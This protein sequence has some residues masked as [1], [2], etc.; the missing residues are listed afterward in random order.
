CCRLR[1][2]FASAP[3]YMARS[4]CG[5]ETGWRVFSG[6][7]S[8]NVPVMGHVGNTRTLYDRFLQVV[9]GLS[10]RAC[11]PVPGDGRMT[12]AT[13]SVLVLVTASLASCGPSSG[14][15]AHV[16]VTDSA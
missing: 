10:R 11:L 15:E 8:V 2:R 9:G 7:R 3:T 4:I 13:I 14:E 12:R 5:A 1:G 16:A 6:S